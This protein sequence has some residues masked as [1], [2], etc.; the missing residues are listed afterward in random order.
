MKRRRDF[1]LFQFIQTSTGFHP[2]YYPMDTG[3]VLFWK[4]GSQGMKLTVHWQVVQELRNVQCAFPFLIWCLTKYRATFYFALYFFINLKDSLVMHSRSYIQHTFQQSSIDL[5]YSCHWH[6]HS[7]PFPFLKAAATVGQWHH[8]LLFIILLLPFLLQGW[9]N[10][11]KHRQHF[12]Q[13]ESKS[14]GHNKK[15][16]C[17]WDSLVMHATHRCLTISSRLK[18]F[19]VTCVQLATNSYLH[20]SQTPKNVCYTAR[21]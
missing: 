7:P 1:S 12:Q 8:T 10:L 6:K 2:V 21:V 18:R 3:E 16:F 11:T 20:I 14:M 13:T 4:Q 17:Q 5:Y 19:Y 15:K 9:N